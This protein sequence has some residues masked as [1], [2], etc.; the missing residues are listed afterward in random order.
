MSTSEPQEPQET[1]ST[2]PQPTEPEPTEPQVN[3]EV[4]R[5]F[6]RRGRCRYGDECRF[7]HVA[8]I[9]T[10]GVQA[11]RDGETRPKRPKRRRK[12]KKKKPA[13]A[14]ETGAPG[15][16]SSSQQPE[17]PADADADADTAP[18]ETPL[19][20]FFAEFEG[21]SYN[22]R[23]SASSEWSRLIRFMDWRPQDRAPDFVD[24]QGRYK[25][26]ISSQFNKIYGTDVNDLTAWQN[27]C[28]VI[29]IA[30]IPN[31]LERCRKKVAF[32]YINL[33]DLVDLPNTGGPL[34]R[35]DNEYQLSRLQ[36]V[37]DIDIRV[38]LLQLLRNLE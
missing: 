32:S 25:A 20:T 35:F 12:P 34:I 3:Q 11:E 23:R 4:C 21:F 38:E 19:D 29:D 5:F 1:Q 14:K 15:E 10:P 24:A 37:V 8:S 13:A 7:Q 31:D 30:P 26:S 16:G 17:A 18:I 22:R 33:V 2:E 27:L 36:D 9:V 28:R 6:A